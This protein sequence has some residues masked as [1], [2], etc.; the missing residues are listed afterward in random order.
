M[1]SNKLV[2][3][4]VE[5]FIETYKEEIAHEFGV[6]HSVQEMDAKAKDMTRTILTKSEKRDCHE[7]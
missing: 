3:P 6:F 5:S 7:K 2:V 1:Q 4:E